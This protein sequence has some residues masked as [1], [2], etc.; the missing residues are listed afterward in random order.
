FDAKQGGHLYLNRTAAGCLA[1]ARL[2]SRFGDA[3]GGAEATRELG[4][5]L[6]ETLRVYRERAQKADDIL[7]QP[8]GKGDLVGNAARPL[9]F[10][11]NNHKSKLALF[12][13]LAP[14]LG[15][16]LAKAA[17]GE[18]EVL[19]R[20]VE[21]LMP[22]FFLAWGERSLHYGENFVDLPDTVH[23]LFLAEAF[24]WRAPAERL[25]R[26]ADLPWSR[27]DL[28]HV[29]KLVHAIEAQG[30]GGKGTP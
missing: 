17:P 15:V 8:V 18:T 27:A 1:Y 14:E 29:E 12:L 4:R 3:D 28:F 13:H 22:A 26:D 30:R 24:L 25:A 7:H 10:H 16:A 20:W 19:H 6:A 5:L 11:L 2:A 23:G 9:Y 21:R